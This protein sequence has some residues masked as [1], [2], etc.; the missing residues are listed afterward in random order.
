[1]N[2]TLSVIRRHWPPLLTLNFLLIASTVYIIINI[3][4]FS[5]PIWKA[6]AQLNIP[7]KGDK[8]NADLGTLGNLSDGSSNFSKEVNPLYTQSA[9]LKSDAVMGRVFASD[10]QKSLFSS[11]EDYKKLFKTEPQA[12]TTVMG[13]EVIGTSPELA[14]TRAK[15]LMDAYQKRLNELRQQDV[16]AQDLFAE[17]SLKK[18]QNNLIVAQNQ[19][20]QFQQST[21]LFEAQTQ[22]QALIQSINQL[23]AKQ[24]DISSEAEANATQSKIAAAQLGMAPEQAIN[25][26][27]LAENKE[28]Q[29]LR[30]KLSATEIELSDS[31]GIY[32]DK[33]PQIQSLQLKRDELRR[34]TNRQIAKVLPG[35]PLSQVDVTLGASNT[36]SR[37]AVIADLI[38]S[39]SM[40]QG[41]KQQATLI[42]KQI[43]Q[44]NS[45]VNFIA[46]NQGVLL[47][48]KRKYEIAEGIYKGI[49][50]QLSQ[51]KISAF[52]AYPSVQ[53]ID[54]PTLDSEPLTASQ[55]LIA[56]GGLLAS[57][58]GS[59]S[60]LLLLES[61]NPLFNSKDLQQAAFPLVLRF[62]RLKS[63]SLA[64]GLDDKS[65]VQFQRLAA[66][67]SSFALEN[68]RLM[69]TS[70]SFGEGK[71]TIT[72][73]LAWALVQLGFRVLL[74][75]ADFRQAEMSRQLGF[76]DFR[77]GSS[78]PAKLLPIHLGFDLMLAPLIQPNKIGEFFLRGEF[79]QRLNRAQASDNYDF[80]LIDSPPVNLTSEASLMSRLIQ[81]VM[82]L[83]RP[84]ISDRYAV[85]DSLEQLK[86]QDAQIKGL[87]VNGVETRTANYRYYGNRQE[88]LE[89]ES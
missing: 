85:M 55:K 75:D 65:E 17:N 76:S 41:L 35:V 74:V 88:I 21:G 87:I 10:P 82:F 70:A 29:S 77:R 50:A 63:P 49:I 86:Q 84:G 42:Q 22:T 78:H 40:A 32:T 44:L 38:R 48:L 13:L 66:I 34:E 64:K 54:G 25:S 73:G 26:L 71:T 59:M 69:I 61:R 14:V 81:N 62:P 45:E 18:A 15:M 2:Y 80:I 72:L 67:V 20:T 83:V 19:L 6:N 53:L 31:K 3:D 79:E 58:F 89:A 12:Q 30:D 46:K 37:T 7:T 52:D 60:L 39:Q 68:R 51:S 5:K 36:D 47:E 4:K 24:T 57:L 11:L 23:R 8:L 27:R 16:K 1:M 28:Y 33:T 9:I 56:L 43:N